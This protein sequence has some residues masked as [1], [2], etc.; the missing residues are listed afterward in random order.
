MTEF[1]VNKKGLTVISESM[2]RQVKVLENAR[3]ILEN[4][5][6]NLSIEGEIKDKLVFELKKLELQIEK[7]KIYIN[8]MS[9]TMHMI[10]ETYGMTEEGL[11]NR[12]DIV[13]TIVARALPINMLNLLYGAPT[14]NLPTDLKTIENI[15]QGLIYGSIR[16]EDY[17]NSTALV[18]ASP[19]WTISKDISDSILSTIQNENED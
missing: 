18:Y 11:R 17:A 7:D 8:K 9:N 1:S 14:I 13:R 10:N 19:K 12:A 6:K 3:E 4:V 15:Q 2:K 5:V 16:L